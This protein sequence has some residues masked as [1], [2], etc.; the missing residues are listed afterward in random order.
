MERLVE[1][2][3]L[4]VMIKERGHYADADS[5][6]RDGP[7]RTRLPM[8]VRSKLYEACGWVRGQLIRE[9]HFVPGPRT[10]WHLAIDHFA[11]FDPFTFDC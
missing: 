4:L 9:L 8:L 2:R 1:K 6:K 3:G 5:A 7:T 11:E 10:G